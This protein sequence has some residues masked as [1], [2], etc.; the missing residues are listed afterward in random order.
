[1]GVVWKHVLRLDESVS[2]L[3]SNLKRKFP[4]CVDPVKDLKDSLDFWKEVYR[5]VTE[6]AE[7]LGAT[8]FKMCM[9][10]ADAI[11]KQKRVVFGI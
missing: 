7:P 2:D 5:C 1:M 4:C 11:L 8:D 9:D 6:I 10:S 3:A